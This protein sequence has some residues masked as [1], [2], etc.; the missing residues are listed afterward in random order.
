MRKLD[1]VVMPPWGMS[2]EKRKQVR[3]S[4]RKFVLA[5]V[6]AEDA[7]N[8]FWNLLSPVSR[9]KQAMVAEWLTKCATACDDFGLDNFDTEVDALLLD[10][11]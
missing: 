3:E 11:V 8:E 7:R 1:S 6:A 4:F 9:E 10:L 2:K 5:A